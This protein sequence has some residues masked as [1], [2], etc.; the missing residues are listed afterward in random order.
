NLYRSAERQGVT[1]SAKPCIHV[2]FLKQAT[3]RA[4]I[5]LQ[6]TLGPRKHTPVPP[7]QLRSGEGAT[8]AS[9]PRQVRIHSLI[10]RAPRSLRKVRSTRA[11]WELRAARATSSGGPCTTSR[12]P[13]SPPS[14]PRPKLQSAS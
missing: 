4:S 10:Q 1:R 2:V 9:R 8:S 7:R 5:V 12:P 6:S 11:V 3:D 13:S 14:G